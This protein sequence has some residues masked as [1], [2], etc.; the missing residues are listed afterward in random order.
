MARK[1]CVK[2]APGLAIRNA[3]AAILTQA[4]LCPELLATK[5]PNRNK[6][7]HASR[8]IHPSQEDILF[9]RSVEVDVEHCPGPNDSKPPNGNFHTTFQNDNFLQHLEQKRIACRA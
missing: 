7:G 3:R 4:M 9:V 1:C 8:G 5:L 6:H 2:I